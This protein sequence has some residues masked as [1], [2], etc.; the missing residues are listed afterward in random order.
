M[1]D[2]VFS[3]PPLASLSVRGSRARFPVRRIYCVGRNYSDH[4][5]EMGG[6]PDREIP[7]FFQ[8]P[9]D[10][11]VENG[12][13]IP[14]PLFTSDFQ[15]EVE[16]LIAIGKEGADIRLD[17]ALDHVFGVGVCIDLTRRDVQVEARKTG[18]PWEI[19]KSFDESA[20]CSEL[21]PVTSAEFPESGAI[22]LRVND[23]TRQHGD[24]RQ[25]IWSSAEVIQQLSTQYR[26][27]PGDLIMT[28]TPAG[29]GP[30][31]PGDRVLA[32]I[33]GIGSLEIEIVQEER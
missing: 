2:F 18:R 13:R 5:R 27:M 20:P 29:V 19:G 23:Q 32:T 7:F 15:H 6:D 17:E 31:T 28:G 11:I 14:Y 4:I 9:T 21:V 24:L 25:M 12:S 3:P 8:K 33:E 30:L 22:E 1:S 16:L 10:S 26:L